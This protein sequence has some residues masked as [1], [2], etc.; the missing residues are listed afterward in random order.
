MEIWGDGK[1]V[2][3]FLYTDD[4][5]EL[6][7]RLAESGCSESLNIGTDEAVSVDGVYDLAAQIAGI[8]IEKI[9]VSGPQGVRG[10]NADLA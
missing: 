6:L 5:L 8:E 9:H 2:R 4:C 10:R 1:A 3:S 7:L